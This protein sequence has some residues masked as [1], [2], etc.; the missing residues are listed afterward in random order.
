MGRQVFDQTGVHEWLAQ[1]TRAW[2]LSRRLVSSLDVV[3]TVVG[4]L[5]TSQM[6]L[7]DSIQYVQTIQSPL[8]KTRNLWHRIM[9]EMSRRNPTRTV[10]RDHPLS[11]G[12][13]TKSCIRFA[14]GLLQKYEHYSKHSLSI[15][16]IHLGRCRAKFWEGS[17]LFWDRLLGVVWVILQYLSCMARRARW[18]ILWFQGLEHPQVRQRRARKSCP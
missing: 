13:N 16:V 3:N 8:M 14:I 15:H 11:H 4:L 17:V 1:Q 7:S 9:F 18:C 6:E 2:F 12:A 5:T 10:R